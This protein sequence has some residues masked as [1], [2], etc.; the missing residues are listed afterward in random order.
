MMK[1][2]K[3]KVGFI[4]LLVIVFIVGCFAGLF[5]SSWLYYR[6]VFS[7]K[8][9]EV[10]GQLALRIN[11]LCKLRLGQVESTIEDLEWLIDSQIVSMAVPHIPITEHRYRVLRNAKT[12]RQLYPSKSESARKVDEIL[13]GIPKI[14]K[15][16]CKSP[17]CRLV[18]Q[19]S[20]QKSE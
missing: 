15:Y 7:Q 1:L 9:D 16:K 2:T 6:H 14:E 17:L 4:V 12:Y 19:K 3:G 10:A 13:A 5:V 18:E 20:S 11:L 8:T